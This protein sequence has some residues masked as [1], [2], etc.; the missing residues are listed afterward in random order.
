MKHLILKERGRKKTKQDSR[1]S[2]SGLDSHPSSG[3]L[4]A[5]TLECGDRQG[6]CASSLWA[7]AHLAGNAYPPG[8]C[9]FDSRD[10]ISPGEMK[11]S[12]LLV[13]GGEAPRVLG[14]LDRYWALQFSIRVQSHLPEVSARE[15]AEAEDPILPTQLQECSTF[16]FPPQ[17][18]LEALS[19]LYLPS[20]PPEPLDF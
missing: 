13:E 8:S 7:P 3:G 4:L 20:Y 19:E 9:C 18:L 5:D 16:Y 6:A 12:G 15:R 10:N 11:G 1:D 17:Y 2:H 14:T